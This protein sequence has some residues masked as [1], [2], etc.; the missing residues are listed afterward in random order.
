MR[1][2]PKFWKKATNA[3]EKLENQLKARSDNI[4]DVDIGYPQNGD[5]NNKQIS[6][7]IHTCE[8]P[9]PT[10]RKAFPKSVDGIP[11]V[12]PTSKRKRKPR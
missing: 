12:P 11:V 9:N 1:L 7:R 5:K 8:D 10:D 3:R 2:N 6:L 4:C